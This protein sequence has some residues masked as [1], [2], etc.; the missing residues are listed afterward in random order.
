MKT[1]PEAKLTLVMDAS[2][3]IAYLRDE[4]GAAEVAAVLSDPAHKLFAHSINLSE[5]FY[6]FHRAGGMDDAVDALSDLSL[7]G[8]VERSD[9]SGEFW[10]AAGKL[11][12]M[13]RRI[14]LADCF[15]ITL[16][17]KLAGTLLT[18]DHHEFDTLAQQSVCDIRFI[19]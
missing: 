17:Q 7:L 9:M 15:A 5:V 19:R 18:S 8:I 6:E 3:M 10:R 11:K 13:Y 1:G 14:S 16:A 12:S 2:A 4:N